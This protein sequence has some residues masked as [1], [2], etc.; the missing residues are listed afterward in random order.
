MGLVSLGDRHQIA[1]ERQVIVTEVTRMSG[2]LVCVA[3][4]DVHSGTMVRPLQTDGSNWEEA[5]WVDTDYMLIGNVLSLVPATPGHPA[6]PHATEDFRVGTVRLLERE[7]LGDLYEACAETADVSV[8]A[9]F[10][11][12]LS[13][14]KYVVAGTECR[15]LGCIM[16]PRGKLKVS[17]FYG[18]VQ[19][20]YHD[21]TYGWHNFSVTDLF[22][23]NLGDAAAGVAALAARIAEASYFR[24]LALRLGLAR[25]WDGGDRGYDPK[26]CFLQLNGLIVPS[27]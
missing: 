9:I 3:A 2:G 13:E 16:L 15:S 7:A 17:E 23:K 14:G 27:S 25:A 10:G 6:Y 8:E 20:S 24:P 22:V 21:E 26:R 1:G 11:G 12:A 19:V 4:L 18:K 5:K